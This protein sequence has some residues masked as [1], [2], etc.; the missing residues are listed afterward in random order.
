MKYANKDEDERNQ[1]EIERGALILVI[2]WGVF[3]LFIA[4]IF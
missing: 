4:W 2:A 1:K 3:W